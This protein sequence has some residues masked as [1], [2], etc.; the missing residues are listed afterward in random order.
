MDNKFALSRRGIGESS[1]LAQLALT[2]YWTTPAPELYDSFVI[3]SVL[4]Q[5]IIDGCKREY[6]V[7]ALSEIERIRAMECMNPRLHEERKDKQV[8]VF[9]SRSASVGQT[10]IAMKIAQCEDAGLPFPKRARMSLMKKSG[11][12]R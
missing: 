11:I 5:V 1:N 6:E 8:H 12:K 7:D 9:N 2:Y 10:L 4:A 3:L